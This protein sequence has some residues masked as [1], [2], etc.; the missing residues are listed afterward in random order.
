MESLCTCWM[1]F[2]HTADNT[3]FIKSTRFMWVTQKK[4]KTRFFRTNS[5]IQTV[6]IELDFNKPISTIRFINHFWTY[7]S[8]LKCM[9]MCDESNTEIYFVI[10]VTNTHI[11]FYSRVLIIKFKV[12][13]VR[14]RPYSYACL[15]HIHIQTP[16]FK[17]K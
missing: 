16:T 15:D 11:S 14:A 10:I 8:R 1:E 17:V 2:T 3:S 4:K 5:S 12:D 6:K 13:T 9:W 7:W